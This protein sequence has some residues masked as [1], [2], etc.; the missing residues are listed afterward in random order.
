M[1]SCGKNDSGQLGRAGKGN[2]PQVI[3][4]LESVKVT[5][6]A[7]GGSKLFQRRFTLTGEFSLAL[8]DEGD[9]WSWGSPEYG[10]IGHGS[11]F[12]SIGAGK[13]S[14]APQKPKKVQGTRQSCGHYL[15]YK[16]V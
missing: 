12:V 1:L 2:K 7:C 6:V 5:K 4:A 15:R 14:F 9:V 3:N 10:Q 8:S 13:T 16:E 11:E